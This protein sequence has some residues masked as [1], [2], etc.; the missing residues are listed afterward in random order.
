MK[1]IPIAALLLLLTIPAGLFSGCAA[2]APAR[3]EPV[4]VAAP[5]TEDLATQLERIFDDPN[6]ANAQWGVKIISLDRGDTVFERNAHRLYMPASNNKVL[7]AAAALVRLGP[8][9]RYETKV[10]TDGEVSDGILKGN[11]IVVGSGDPSM[12]GRFHENDPLRVLK[13]WAAALKGKGIRKIEGNLLG[14][15]SAFAEP[16]FGRGWEWDDLAFGY[17]APVSALQFNENL[18]TLEIAPA[19][20]EG[21]KASVKASPLGDYLTLDFGV[22]TAAAG[23]DRRL[24]YLAAEGRETL[25]VRGTIP[26]KGNPATQTVAVREPTRYFLEALRH[27]LQLEGIEVTG[28]SAR[29]PES[30][31]GASAA[32]A[33]V[34]LSHQSHPLAE[35][36]K[37][38]LKVSQNLYAE[39]MARTLGLAARGQ[40][41]FEAG[42]EVLQEALRTMAI[43]RETYMYADGS[44]LSRQNLIS[45][46]LLIR[47]FRSMYRHRSFPQFYD[48]LPIAGVDG[49][50]RTRLRGTKAENNVRAKTGTIANVRALSGYVRSADGEMFAFAMM[51]NNFLVSSRTAEYVQDA[52]LELLANFRR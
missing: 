43:E 22:T 47:I 8:D 35:I 46:E 45:A 7:T 3:V 12:A 11:L 20:R 41:S 13:G 32:S 29:M 33:T 51:A 28:F 17:A 10:V 36:L 49:T 39:T 1:R 16:V 50:I 52:A 38:L 19:E 42:R 48:A 37:P 2:K 31:V 44:G 18:L 24:E 6:F 34:L 9:F 14:D 15:D 5:S 30:D 27:C 21:E 23:S 4:P 40:G 26:V 25:R